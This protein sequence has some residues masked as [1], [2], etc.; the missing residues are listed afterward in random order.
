M[1]NEQ[2]KPKKPFAMEYDEAEREIINAVNSAHSEH[3][4]PFIFIEKTLTILLYQVKENA[5][6]EK[7]M[8]RQSYEKQMEE[9]IKVESEDGKDGFGA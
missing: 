4:V 7:E 6:A 1:S 8:A 9:Y 5:R 3:G 2:T